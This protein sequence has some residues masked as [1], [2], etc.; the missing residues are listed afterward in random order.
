ML[1]GPTRH[2]S[3]SLYSGSSCSA[4]KAWM[5]EHNVFIWL[6]SMSALSSSLC[7][8]ALPHMLSEHRSH[9]CRG[10]GVTIVSHL[11]GRWRDDSVTP[12]GEVA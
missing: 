7:R 11:P 2:I 6:N 4:M 12:A 9:T 10:G 1:P 3:T 5:R 8:F